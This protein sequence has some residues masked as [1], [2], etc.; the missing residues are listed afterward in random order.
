MLDSL[1]YYPQAGVEFIF[2]PTTSTFL[3]RGK[4]SPAMHSYLADT[5]NADRR[6]VVGGILQRRK[7]GVFITNEQ[8]GH[9]YQNWT[10]ER[11][12][13]FIDTMKKYGITILHSEGIQWK[14]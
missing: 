6:A 1:N 13:Q 10:P 8:S 12:V 11:R 2:D 4:K 14:Y 7:D 5:I 9:F 3:V